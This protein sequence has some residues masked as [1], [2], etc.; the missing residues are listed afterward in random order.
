MTEPT[1]LAAAA[2][3]IVLCR[4]PDAKISRSAAVAKAWRAGALAIEARP[5]EVPLEPGRPELPKLLPPTEMPRR[6]SGETGRLALLHAVAHIEFNAINLAWDLVA[7]FGPELGEK[8]FLDDWVSVGAEEALHFNM[9]R[10]RLRALGSDYGAFPA[11]DGL[12]EAAAETADNLTARLAIVPLVLEAR[13][14]DV[15]PP[16]AEKLKSAGDPESAALLMRIYEDEIGHVAAG[17]RAFRHV[18]A[19]S[20][21]DPAATYHQLVQERFKGGLKP[22]FN[23]DGRNAAGLLP[24]FYLNM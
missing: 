2:R 14:L 6:T 13:G 1:G 11:H 10:A 15:G 12:W 8:G 20:G 22:P 17:M 23:A 4:D 21:Q 9:I 5:I 24:D 3:D 16:M 19:K 18:C 7:R